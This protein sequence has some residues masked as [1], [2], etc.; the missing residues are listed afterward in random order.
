MKT[1]KDLNLQDF[2]IFKRYIRRER[3]YITRRRNNKNK[4]TNKNNYYLF[5]IVLFIL[6]IKNISA[7]TYIELKFNKEG[8]NQII[9]SCYST[10]LSYKIYINNRITNLQGKIIDVNSINDIIKIKWD[11]EIT[12]ISYMFSNLK[13]ITYAKMNYEFASNN[14]ITMDYMFKDCSNLLYFDY[15]HN[16]HYI[17]RISGMFYNCISLTSF[18]FD[19]FYISSIRN[20]IIKKLD[21]S[22]MF[23]NCQNLKSIS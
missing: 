2:I 18:A 7:G 12:N 1:E 10:A 15:V 17:S 20:N 8:P 4:Y 5:Y 16:S 21:M 3:N 19:N 6:I 23:F 14:V 11:Q 22:Y 13:T 9:S